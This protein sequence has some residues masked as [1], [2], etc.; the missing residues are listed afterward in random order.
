MVEKY[1][2][3]VVAERCVFPLPGEPEPTWESMLPD[4]QLRRLRQYSDVIRTS[5]VTT[6]VKSLDEVDGVEAIRSSDFG[7][8]VEACE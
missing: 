6:V 3:D 4:G 5:A 7:D 8:V 2:N 1:F